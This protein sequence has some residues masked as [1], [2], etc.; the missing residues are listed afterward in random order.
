[1]G[2]AVVAVVEVEE[3]GQDKMVRFNGRKA[4]ERNVAYKVT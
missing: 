1:V 2:A 4:V 3:E